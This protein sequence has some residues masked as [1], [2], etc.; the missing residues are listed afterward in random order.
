M[1]GQNATAS[2]PSSINE[3]AYTAPLI[4]TRETWGMICTMHENPR[5]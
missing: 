4:L 3:E 2:A 1:C 5:G